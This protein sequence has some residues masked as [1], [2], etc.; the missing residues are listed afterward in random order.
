MNEKNIEFLIRIAERYYSTSSAIVLPRYANAREYAFETFDGKFVRHIGLGDGNEKEL[1]MNF[2][3]KVL[4]KIPRGVYYSSACYKDPANRNMEAK[5]W[6]GTELIFDLDA[7]HIEDAQNLSYEESLKLVRK[8]TIKLVEI[9]ENDFGLEDKLEIVFSGRRGYHVHV[10]SDDFMKLDADT[11]R[12]IIKYIELKEVDIERLY[13]RAVAGKIH[14][15][16]WLKRYV[17]F[18]SR[19]VNESK[20]KSLLLLKIKSQM[21]KISKKDIDSTILKCLDYFSKDNIERLSIIVE[22]ARRAKDKRREKIFE[23]IF[24]A[25]WQE[26]VKECTPHI[27]E[28]VTAD[29][30]RLIRLPNTLHGKT[31]LRAVP[32]NRDELPNFDPLKSAILQQLKNVEIEVDVLRDTKVRIGNEE[33]SFNSGIQKVDGLVGIY[34]LCN[35]IANIIKYNLLEIK[36]LK[37]R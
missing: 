26:F 17:E 8:E 23:S 4:S 22:N 36:S 5:G 13:Y 6:I 16:P 31:F 1:Y 20:D 27:D 28:L 21:K 11:R 33:Y 10:S 9:L 34:M 15:R 25:F 29:I 30:S 37:F 35:N 24:K 7:D 18:I 2:R 14:N 3:K 12:E 32:V 19:Q